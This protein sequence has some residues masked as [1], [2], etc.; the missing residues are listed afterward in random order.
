MIT[1]LRQFWLPL[2]IVVIALPVIVL[3]SDRA[4]YNRTVLAESYEDSDLEL[5]GRKLKGFALG[6][7]GLLADWYW[8]R[9]L[10]YLGNK[11]VKTEDKDLNLEDL[12]PLNPRLLFPLLDNTTDLDPKFISAYSFGAIVLPAIDRQTAIKLTEK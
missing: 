8:I 4:N 7:E 10:Q 1:F 11:I 12:R 3:I 5:N 6:A 9:A 2:V